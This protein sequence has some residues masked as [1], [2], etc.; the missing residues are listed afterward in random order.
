MKMKPLPIS[1]CRRLFR[2]IPGVR[3][4]E[5]YA[6][7]SARRARTLHSGWFTMFMKPRPVVARRTP[8]TG[9]GFVG[10]VGMCWASYSGLSCWM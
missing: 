6:V 5:S 3:I 9:R 8:T 7:P 4:L 10:G 2:S 1:S